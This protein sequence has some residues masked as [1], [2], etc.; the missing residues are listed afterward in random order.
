MRRLFPCAA[1]AVLLGGCAGNVPSGMEEPPTT[2]TVPGKYAFTLVSDC[3]ERALIGKFRVTVESDKVTR[4][5]GLDDAARRAMMLRLANLV[6]TLRQLEDE[7]ETARR[8][9]AEVV[10]VE[11]DISDAHPVRIVIDK[12]ASAADDESC[13]TIEDYTIGLAA[14][15]SATPSR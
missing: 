2:W 1:L 14:E 12:S 15:P 9:G 11:R 4:A 7:A 10:Q 13:Y 3:G 8:E 6:P 5:E